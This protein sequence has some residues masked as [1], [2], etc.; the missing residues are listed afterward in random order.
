[1]TDSISREQAVA[2]EN[3][4]LADLL[5]RARA[6]MKERLQKIREN[7]NDCD[8]AKE[9]DCIECAED[10]HRLNELEFALGLL[11]ERET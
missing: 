7:I 10:M 8:W 4:R 5:S 6:G 1:M 2:A 9:G 3:Q 11:R